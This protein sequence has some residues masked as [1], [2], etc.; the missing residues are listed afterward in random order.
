MTDSTRVHLTCQPIVNSSP[1]LTSHGVRTDIRPNMTVRSTPIMHETDAQ[2]TSASRFLGTLQF[3]QLQRNSLIHVLVGV[4]IHLA[5]G[6]LRVLSA[7]PRLF[8][9]R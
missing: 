6:Q 5:I 8:A 4:L 3:K 7:D 1:L 9:D 2:W